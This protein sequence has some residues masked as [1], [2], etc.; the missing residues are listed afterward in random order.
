MKTK[1]NGSNPL[2]RAYW[3]LQGPIAVRD[4]PTRISVAIRD[5]HRGELTPEIRRDTRRKFERLIALGNFE[6]SSLDPHPSSPSSCPYR[7]PRTRRSRRLFIIISGLLE[8]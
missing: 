5:K 4:G 1:T 6:G 8:A 7:Y 2:K 3:A